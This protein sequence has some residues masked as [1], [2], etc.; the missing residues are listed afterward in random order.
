M[1]TLET[2]CCQNLDCPDVGLRGKGNLRWHGYSGHKQK[3]RSHIPHT[4][5]L[6]H[7][8]SFLLDFRIT[9]PQN[10]AFLVHAIH[11][12]TPTGASSHFQEKNKS[13]A[14][15]KT[16]QGHPTRPKIAFYS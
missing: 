10:G 8:N 3:N 4:P 11:R 14:T 7:S 12:M 13:M 6:C 2:F 1:P 16:Q 9:E 5:A 15:Q